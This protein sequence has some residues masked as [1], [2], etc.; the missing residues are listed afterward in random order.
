MNDLHIQRCFSANAKFVF[1]SQNESLT[2]QTQTMHLTPHKHHSAAESL[3]QS[4]P[5]STAHPATAF[6]SPPT[7]PAQV[8]LLPHFLS[9]LQKTDDFC[10][11]S[12]QGHTYDKQSSSLK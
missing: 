8:L 4:I 11:Q 12:R 5:S 9:L 1:M 10:V 6:P 7:F 3:N 2:A